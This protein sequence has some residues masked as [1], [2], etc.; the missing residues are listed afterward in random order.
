MFLF[1]HIHLSWTKVLMEGGE[2]SDSETEIQT[3]ITTALRKPKMYGVILLNDD[4]TP[5]DF[6]TLVLR[7]FFSKN[8]A[9]ATKIMLDIHQKGSG[10]AGVYSLEVAEM[11]IMQTHQTAQ[12]HQYPLKAVLKEIS[13][14]D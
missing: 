6:V 12:L 5:M 13:D 7:R 10:L 14:T 9:E 2:H 4:Y 1:Q 8:E 3:G 11:K